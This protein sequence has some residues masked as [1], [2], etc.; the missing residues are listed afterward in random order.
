MQRTSIIRSRIIGNR[1]PKRRDLLRDGRFALHTFPNP[2]VDDEFTVSGRATRVDDPAVR[3]IVYDTYVA[4]GAFTSDDT[5]FE[6]RFDRA[7]HAKYETRPS[8][9]P[10]YTRWPGTSRTAT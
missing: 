1:S 8:W 7:L 2:T 10:V 6:L 5:L 3:K 9:P 4:T